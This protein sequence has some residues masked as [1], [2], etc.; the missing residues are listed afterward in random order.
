MGDPEADQRQVARGAAAVQLAEKPQLIGEGGAEQ[1]VQA[2]RLAWSAVDRRVV[3]RRAPAR[4]VR[5]V[6]SRDHPT[7]R[8]RCWREN[9]LDPSVFDGGLRSAFQKRRS[10]V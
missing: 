5:G 10:A 8:H 9:N 7:V 3:L 4:C 2:P 1:R 6:L